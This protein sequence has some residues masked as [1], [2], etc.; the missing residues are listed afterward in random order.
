MIAAATLRAPEADA[1]LLVLTAS[2][3]LRHAPRTS[4]VEFLQRTL[5]SIPTVVG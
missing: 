4:L 3:E 1:R 2:A 5:Q